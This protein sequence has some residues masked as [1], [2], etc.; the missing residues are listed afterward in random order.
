MAR[1][2]AFRGF[3]CDR[4]MKQPFRDGHV[5]RIKCDS[6]TRHRADVDRGDVAVVDEQAA[7]HEH[8]NVGV[9][10]CSSRAMRATARKDAINDPAVGY[11]PPSGDAQRLRQRPRL[12]LMRAPPAG[13]G[14]TEPPLVTTCWP[15]P[16]VWLG[17]RN[18]DFGKKVDL[19][20]K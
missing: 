11:A 10:R 15:V 7:R 16:G 20:T 8:G 6:S 18:I 1:H 2:D 4:E 12:S 5:V 14:T 9:R 17:V 13:G 19:R 3:G